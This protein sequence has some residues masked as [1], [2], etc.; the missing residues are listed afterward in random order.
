MQDVSIAHTRLTLPTV[1]QLPPSICPCP[2]LQAR[3]TLMREGLGWIG[4]LLPGLQV[5]PSF[6]CLDLQL[7]AL[8]FSHP[9]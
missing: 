5:G 8:L 7:W 2:C 3:Y 4:G 9:L 6:C 1:P